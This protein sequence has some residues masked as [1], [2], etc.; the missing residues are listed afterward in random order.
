MG[1]RSATPAT[2][3]LALLRPDRAQPCG[4]LTWNPSLVLRSIIRPL[5]YE[6]E[7]P[8]SNVAATQ[9]EESSRF[10]A[11]LSVQ[12]SFNDFLGTLAPDLVPAGIPWEVTCRISLTRGSGTIDV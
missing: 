11:N 7:I 3:T 12:R 1:Q 9:T 4:R 5:V 6:R 2:F 10:G 8:G